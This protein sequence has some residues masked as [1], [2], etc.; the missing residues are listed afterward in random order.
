MNRIQDVS[1]KYFRASVLCVAPEILGQPLAHQPGYQL[2]NRVERLLHVRSENRISSTTSV[3]LATAL[4][5]VE[6]AY[7]TRGV[8]LYHWLSCGGTDS[9]GPI[10]GISRGR[11][12]QASLHTPTLAAIVRLTRRVYSIFPT[13]SRN[14]PRRGT[15]GSGD[16]R[17]HSPIADQAKRPYAVVRNGLTGVCSFRLSPFATLVAG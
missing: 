6:G 13:H 10:T 14:G 5:S 17:P 7:Q 1:F 8:Y 11:C 3:P 15:V 2:V 12:T 9:H 4:R 16:F